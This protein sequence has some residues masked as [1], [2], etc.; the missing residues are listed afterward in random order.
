METSL[1]SVSS[2]LI[3]LI[4]SQLLGTESYVKGDE[5]IKM[6]DD[7]LDLELDTMSLCQSTRH[8][9]VP[10]VLSEKMYDSQTS[11]SRLSSEL[12]CKDHIRSNSNSA[13]LDTA[14]SPLSGDMPSLEMAWNEEPVPTTLPEAL[15]QQSC[16]VTTDTETLIREHKGDDQC[17]T[18]RL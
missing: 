1:P 3:A 7:L 14:L 8:D 5:N 4:E 9:S 18:C 13:L 2:D 16:W 6:A 17:T 11:N 12:W 10:R 15:L